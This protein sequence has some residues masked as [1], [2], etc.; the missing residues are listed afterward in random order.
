[1]DWLCP[2]LVRDGVGEILWLLYLCTAL[3]LSKIVTEFGVHVGLALEDV[4]FVPL[5]NL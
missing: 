2:L 4:N 5:Q 1:M 3:T